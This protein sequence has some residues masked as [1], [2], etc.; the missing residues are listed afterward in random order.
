MCV[1]VLTNI[2]SF[3]HKSIII[4]HRVIIIIKQNPITIITGLLFIPFTFTLLHLCVAA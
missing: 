1:C 4:G 2:N 3:S